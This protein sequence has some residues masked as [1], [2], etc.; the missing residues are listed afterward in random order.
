MA[1]P[2]QLT[3]GMDP[4]TMTAAINDMF[5]QVEAENRTKIIK[6]ETG[7]N[8][9]IIGRGPDGKYGLRVSMPTKDVLK[10]EN[11]DLVFNSNQNTF[12]IVHTG[13]LNLT[14]SGD[15]YS[16]AEYAH[17]LGFVPSFM[18]YYVDIAGAGPNAGEHFGQQLPFQLFDND[19]GTLWVQLSAYATD[20]VF[21]VNLFVPHS[22]PFDGSVGDPWPVKFYLMQETSV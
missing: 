2:I 8:R 11:N 9:I 22:S 10:S 13:T 14:S 18:A 17:N 1:A 3:P 7:V 19:D 6:D 15:L 21:G 5:R 16:S 12:K 4:S 20:T